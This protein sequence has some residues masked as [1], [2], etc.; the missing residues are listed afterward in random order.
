MAEACA[1]CRQELRV[2]RERGN[3]LMQG[4]ATGLRPGDALVQLVTA[5][6]EELDQQRA[7]P[8]ERRR[9]A[10]QGVGRERQAAWEIERES[11][12]AWSPGREPGSAAA[13]GAAG[14]QI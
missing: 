9:Q 6:L 2:L 10:Q 1:P 3:A 12:H 14:E 8:A 5:A 4:G 13:W 7:R 11:D